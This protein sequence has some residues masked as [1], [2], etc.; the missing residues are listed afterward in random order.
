MQTIDFLSFR[1]DPVPERSDWVRRNGEI[2]VISN[3]SNHKKQVV[4]DESKDFVNNLMLKASILGL[5]ERSELDAYYFNR[6][7]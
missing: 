4:D 1:L 5:K 2:S 6:G 3:L 7:V